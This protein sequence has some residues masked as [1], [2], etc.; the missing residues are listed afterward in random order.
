[1]EIIVHQAI[2]GEQNKAWELLRTTL[3]D[4]S[5][6][7]KIAFQTDLQDSP[8]SGVTWLPVIRGFLFNN[9]FL[10]IKTYPD[11][12]P[13]VRNGRVF[14]HCLIIDK[15]DL[16][17]ISDISPLLSTFKDEIDKTI[18][19][20]PI[21]LTSNQQEKVVLKDTLQLRFNKVIQSF[22]NFTNNLVPLIWVGQKHFEIAV[23]K[24]WQLLSATQREDFNFGINFNPNEVVKN[25]LSFVVIPD[26]SINKFEN[27]GFS[28][29]RKEDSV[30]LKEF[31]EQFLA[32]EPNAISRIEAF[33]SEIGASK[34]SV[35]EIS[36]IA[37]GIPTYEN[38]DKETDLKLLNTLSNII[39][40]YSPNE[41]KGIFIKSR[42]VQRISSLAE[43][44]DET[45]IYPLRNFQ[46]KSFKN[47]EGV[48]SKAIEK[49]IDNYLLSE[50]ENTKKDFAPTILQVYDSS[51]PLWW[52][53][54][55]KVKISDFVNSINKS[56]A[57]I[58]WKW[59]ISEIKLLKVI[60]SEIDS[61]KSAEILFIDT[62]SP[63]LEK[64][65]LKEVKIFSV[66]K[67]WLKLH[68]TIVKT[69]Y[70]FAEAIAEQLKVDMDENYLEA[71]E[72]ITK[73]VEPQ[74]IINITILNGNKK[75]ISISGVLCK[76]NPLLLEKIEIDNT[77]WQDILLASVKNGNKIT[78]GIKNPQKIFYSFYDNIIN[79]KSYNIELLEKISDTDFA[80]I[81]NYPNRE[82]FWGML[83]DYLI[84][85]FLDKTSSTL[86][87]GLSKNSTVQ[88]PIDNELSSYIL[89]NGISTFLY[90]NR[91]N[92]KAAL[93]IFNTFSHLPEYII[94]DY[95]S[96][97]SAKLDVVDSTQIG[98]L[99]TKRNFREVAYKI[100]EKAVHNKSFRVALV[101]CS[102][103]L[104][105]LTRGFA[106]GLGLI[107]NIEISEDE[108]WAA[109]TELSY[110][111][112]SSGPTE[113][114]IWNQ[115]DG[116]EYDLLTKGTGKEV[117]I[118]ALEK[119]RQK[120]CTGIT[121]KKLLKVMH[122]EHP[123]NDELK[124]LKDLWNNL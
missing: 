85:K 3:E 67:D 57:K 11:N 90:Y 68:A 20:Q 97:Y 88:V 69:E 25:K 118:S 9:Y 66:K 73:G 103:L 110:K 83:P 6:G 74:E 38:L 75:C 35:K 122:G 108:W 39:A 58:I 56:K 100:Y 22:I 23:C 101:E 124:T 80:N 98:K 61:S 114:K 21:I 12:S 37:K 7:K 28:I 86:L 93:P 48:I 81:L 116:K 95:V 94:R 113:N 16:A 34:P 99:V 72:I 1:M 96:N 5:I 71:L 106:W 63:P 27:N 18:Q 52:A 24:V 45:E 2:C 115:A 77:I 91:N 120:G 31:A 30:E 121:V 64:G 8:P 44:A 84:A 54:L 42:L 112:Y 43:T 47:S 15:V 92:I 29:I 33:I 79:G 49:W 111:L 65:I 13:D 32:G 14:S 107:S 40:K 53:K 89:S 60:S 82:F 123:K 4:N 50:L 117:W 36:T 104:D 119:L 17:N 78:D 102:P 76:A 55:F 59:I 87:E 26:N 105:F 70:K 19:L 109:F 41:N 51:S 62:F 10:L 46:I